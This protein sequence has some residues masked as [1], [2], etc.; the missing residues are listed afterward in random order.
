MY[1]E[2]PGDSLKLFFYFLLHHSAATFHPAA[3][4]CS[5]GGSVAM[6]HPGNV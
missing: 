1:D 2:W 6:A 3:P 5:Q 4:W